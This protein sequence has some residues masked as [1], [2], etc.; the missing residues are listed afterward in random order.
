MRLLL[1]SL[2]FLPLLV[3]AEPE[4]PWSP[5]PIDPL[6][7]SEAFRKSITGSYGIDSRIE[8]TITV[9]EEAYLRDSAEAMAA[10]DRE[11]AIQILI[12]SDIS[13]RSPAIAFQ[14]GSLLFEKGDL[15]AAAEKLESAL[16]QFPNFRDAHRNLAILRLQQDKAEES[17]PHLVRAVELGSREG[18]TMGLLGYCHALKGNQQAALDAYRLASLTQPEERQWITGQAQALSQLGQTKEAL[19]LYENL[20]TKDPT[21]FNLWLLQSDA[22]VRLEKDTKAIASLELVRR[23]KAL[24][25]DGSLSLGHLFAR[26]NLTDDALANYL[27]AVSAEQPVPF[28]NA[29]EAVEMLIQT[30]QYTRAKTLTEALRSTYE[31]ENGRLVRA[32]AIIEMQTGDATSAAKKLEDWIARNPTDG[33][34]L[35]LLAKYLETSDRIEE[36]EMRLEQAASFPDHTAAAKRALGEL[37][38]ATGDYKS[39]VAHLKA[40][41]ELQPDEA[42]QA[43]LE[44]VEELV[45]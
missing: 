2:L 8:P 40:S 38:V 4:N 30:Q 14:L 44:A 10:D 29:V 25:P 43:Y 45:D 23:G 36:A 1:I 16:K 37:K 7:K 24:S 9:D 12:D 31:E 28:A 35:I 34:T 18:L 19:S 41:L 11:K 13:N 32:D 22:F 21:S 20:I 26:N 17:F 15:D 3:S 6:W 39:A 33:E 42:L 27:A 5:L